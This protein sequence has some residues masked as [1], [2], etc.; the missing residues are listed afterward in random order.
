MS[1]SRVQRSALKHPSHSANDDEFDL[2]PD[3][4]RD[5]LSEAHRQAVLRLLAD[6]SPLARTRGAPSVTCGA[7]NGLASGRHRCRRRRPLHLGSRARTRENQPQLDQRTTALC[8]ALAGRA[9]SCRI[10]AESCVRECPLLSSAVIGQLRDMAR[11]TVNFATLRN[12]RDGFQNPFSLR[13]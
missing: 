6:R 3:E 4:G 13:A 8:E 11:K 12:R 7:S 2:V 9:A 1:R 5:D 10:C